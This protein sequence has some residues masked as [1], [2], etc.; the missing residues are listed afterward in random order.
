MDWGEPQ[1]CGDGY[2]V[3]SLPDYCQ[4]TVILN[5][6]TVA[7]LLDNAYHLRFAN[8]LEFLQCCSESPVDLSNEPYDYAFERGEHR[9]LVDQ[10]PLDEDA[11]TWQFFEMLSR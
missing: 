10:F 3:V 11:C 8:F 1:T 7:M 4:Y 9:K 5:L 6:P 2:N